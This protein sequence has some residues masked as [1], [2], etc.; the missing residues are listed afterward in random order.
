MDDIQMLNIKSALEIKRLGADLEKAFHQEQQRRLLAAYEMYL[1]ELE[2]W[3]AKN[4]SIRALKEL[5]EIHAK[6]GA[7]ALQVGNEDS[8]RHAKE[9]YSRAI[10]LLTQALEQTDDP[11]LRLLLCS[12]CHT[13]VTISSQVDVQRLYSDQA[14]LAMKEIHHSVRIVDFLYSHTLIC[15]YEDLDKAYSLSPDVH[16]RLKGHNAR[17]Q[18]EK[19]RRW[20]AQTKAQEAT[21]NLMQHYH[22]NS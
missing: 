17:L 8:R 12:Y 13:L 19:L 14:Y 3:V 1:P 4:N 9:R 11:R 16:C 6:A 7:A 5:A 15:I 18:A 22:T 20:Q 10:A 2:D 21:Y